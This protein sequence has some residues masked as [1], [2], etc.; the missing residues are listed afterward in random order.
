MLNLS[1]KKIIDVK[2]PLKLAQKKSESKKI[3]ILATKSAIESK[4]LKNY[5]KENNI[6]KSYKIFKINGS[7]LVDL[8]ESGKF[9]NK[10]SYCKKI[11][12]ESLEDIIIS[13]KID[14]IT[15]SSTHLLFLKNY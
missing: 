9:L 6:P 1:S 12:K 11:I 2:P 3:G 14:V 7:N 4:G 8:V 15:L 10:K 13:E 5:I